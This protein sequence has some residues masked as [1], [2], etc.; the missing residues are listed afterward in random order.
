MA[1][2]VRARDTS[3]PGQP[4]VAVKRILPHLRDDQQYKT[5]FLD[6]SRVLAQLDHDAIIKTFEIGEAESTP[7]IALEY[8]DGQDARNLFHR[9]RRNNE[10][11]PIS[12]ACYIIARV[13][14]GLHHAHE[15]TDAQGELLGLVHRDVSLQNVLLS[16][17]GD[18][19]ITDFGIAM[20]TENVARTEAGIVKGKFG[21]MSPEQIKGAPLDRRSDV[22]AAGI[23]LYELLTGERLF[24]GES[25]YKAVE[26][27]RNVDVQPPSSF[28][29]EIPSSLE[30]IV[31]KAL[32]KHP[33]DR[34]QSA[35]DLRRALHTF[36]T[37]SK[38]ECSRAELGA[39]LRR[40]FADDMNAEPAR[41]DQTPAPSARADLTPAR[42]APSVPPASPA[43]AAQS[44]PPPRS[45]PSIAPAP[46][47]PMPAR[48]STS[49]PAPAA[50]PASVSGSKGSKVSPPTAA[51]RPS[52]PQ[53]NAPQPTERMPPVDPLTGLAAFDNLEQV[54]ALNL[55]PE[56]APPSAS[57]LH[58]L[59]AP[60]ADVTPY[61]AEP[62]RARAHSVPPVVPRADSIPGFAENEIVA[63]ALQG[64]VK[65][66]SAPTLDMDWDDDEPATQSQGL[67]EIPRLPDAELSEPGDNDVTR[68]VRVDETFPGLRAEQSGEFPPSLELPRQ[69]V[70]AMQ[71][72]EHSAP[73]PPMAAPSSSATFPAPAIERSYLPV[74]AVVVGIIAVIAAA[75]YAFRDPGTATIHLAT[76]PKDA[77]VIV[78]GQR[79]PART[80]P[81]V[82]SE[83]KAGVEHTIAV[84]KPGFSAW[85]TRLRVHGNQV[86]DLPAVTL[87]PAVGA[88]PPAAPVE[89][90]IA[91]ELPAEKP[92][93]SAEPARPSEPM[94]APTPA[95]RDINSVRPTPRP[96]SARPNPEHSAHVAP[97]V[98][99]AAALHAHTAHEHAPAPAPFAHAAK[100]AAAEKPAATG[101]TGVL[102]INTRPWS[103][104]FVDGKLIGNTPQMNIV[105]PP[106][107]HQLKLVNPDFGMT[108]TLSIDIAAGKTVT[109]VLSL[110]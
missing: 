15:Q 18:V 103:R 100:P 14:E 89:N 78:D 65:A 79:V 68:Q 73:T 53:P 110:Q 36:M 17:D 86:L 42:P 75:L 85:S 71:A 81:F 46:L 104:V 99:H 31:M 60:Y 22:F 27:V 45:T 4:I 8:I 29:R 57:A 102:R 66:P 50:P 84:E 11:V 83:V 7:Y 5:M 3:A 105:L 25:D 92:A 2:I 59:P 94:L 74:V 24:S 47:P 56:P 95:P 80:S 108:K 64:S 33:R 62:A 6:E 9:T 1:E 77:I 70:Q 44:V 49:I 87:E 28:N 93:S 96:A 43:R 12:V 23:C 39:Y 58:A 52:A 98:T 69:A 101:G 107:K 109:K 26:R 51:A 32:A 55:M 13:C 76:E 20:S 106:G 88:S 61:V 41:L 16:Y 10:R 48:V 91:K 19:K 37:D 30:R 63:A 35:N 97:A 82:I 54:S 67:D 38:Q 72:A 21:Y 34:Y 40:L 90:P